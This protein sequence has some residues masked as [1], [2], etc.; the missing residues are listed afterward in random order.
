MFMRWNSIFED[1]YPTEVIFLDHCA[2]GKFPESFQQI[3]KY[4]IGIEGKY[5]VLYRYNI[6]TCQL[7][8]VIV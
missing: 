5:I 7:M 1:I 4:W 8:M 3:E 2:I 6:G